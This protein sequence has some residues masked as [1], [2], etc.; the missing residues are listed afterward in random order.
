MRLYLIRHGDPDY[1]HDSL[2]PA[3]QRQAQAL[4]EAGPAR[5]DLLLCSPL[6]R[7]Q[8][9]AA[10]LAAGRGL[11]VQ[12]EPWLREMDDVTV[13]HKTRPDLA[14]WNLGPEVL[15]RVPPENWTQA[16]PF[17]GSGLEARWQELCSGADRWLADLGLMRQGGG[18][19]TC[20]ETRL[21]EAVALTTHLGAG[22]A[23]LAHLLGV[24]PAILWATSYLPPCSI[25][26]LLLEQQAE[27]D[28]FRLIGMGNVG[29]LRRCGAPVTWSGL[30]TA[31]TL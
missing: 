22:L 11:A 3:G 12:T 2:T 16:A 30:R 29:H 25:T 26:T 27:G 4:A 13:P 28:H 14:V 31:G 1:T 21:P 20:P 18:W 24:C 8:R 19:H 15:L 17:Q 23:L 7:A 5:L 9:T 6:G 10:P